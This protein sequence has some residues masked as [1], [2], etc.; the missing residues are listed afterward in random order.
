MAELKRHA[1]VMEKLNLALPRDELHLLLVSP[2]L[3]HRSD[4][5]TRWAP[6]SYCTQSSSLL[7]HATTH[8]SRTRE[9]LH[10]DI[11]APRART[12]AATACFIPEPRSLHELLSPV[13]GGVI[14]SRGTTAAP[15]HFIHV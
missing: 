1:L 5:Q 10:P 14:P 2:F 3:H 15:I 11:G 8:D 12:A 6:G 7:A 13:L 9:A 4:P